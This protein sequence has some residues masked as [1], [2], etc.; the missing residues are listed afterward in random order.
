MVVP[1]GLAKFDSASAMA[2]ALARFLHGRDFPALG[3]AK[4]L[5]WLVQFADLVPRALRERLFAWLGAM[6]G[7]P[8]ADV[9]QVNTGRL[10]EW[11]TGLYP[12]RRYPAVMIGSSNGALVHLAAA[13]GIPWLPQTLLT[14]VR[15][16]QVH[17]D[18]GAQAME[19]GRDAAGRFLAANPDVQ[20]HHMHDPS[21]DRLMS[22]LVTYFRFKYRR[23][24]PAY[25]AFL[26]RWLE[27]QGTIVIVDCRHRWPVTRL[28]ERHVFQFGAIGGP[29]KEEYF[30]GGERVEQYLAR[31][32]STFRRWE[33]PAPN[34]G[35]PE[36]EWGFEPALEEDIGAFAR[37]HRHRVVRLAFND[38]EDVSAP[39]A[40]LYRD[41]YAERGIPASRL[42]IES[43]VLLEP[44]WVLRTGS[45]P[46]WMTFNMEP[47]LEAVQRYLSGAAPYEQLH[48]MLFA[49]GVNS[50]GL[51][52]IEDWRRLLE[53]ARQ[54]GS[55]L[56]VN[57]RAYPAHF[58]SFAK[59]SSAVR[60]LPARHPLP[61]PLPFKCLAEFLAGMPR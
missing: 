52:P 4:T 44:Y 59:Y 39:V 36:A 31:Y 34:D 8:P 6:E 51:P 17:P 14:L 58:A 60:A 25:R 61:P 29:T 53:R 20:L 7:V 16:E 1:V 40:D 35:S 49:H 18:D 24:P 33:P 11:V 48:L 28:G 13:F 42:V 9:G 57:P 32:G 15:Q 43:F 56:G 3:Q 41:W 22:P 19:A 10:A 27:P 46:F 47:S 2:Q 54:G 30:H 26:D 23:L 12:A 50:V 5:R 38:P 37:R 55:F 45:V 21:Q